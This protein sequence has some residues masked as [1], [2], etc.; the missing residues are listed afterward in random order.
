MTP[1]PFAV[2]ALV[3]VGGLGAYGLRRARQADIP[4]ALNTATKAVVI[5][6]VAALGLVLANS[7]D[8]PAVLPAV[9]GSL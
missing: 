5:L 1:L 8:I 4:A 2:L 9:L 7:A 6:A 3:V